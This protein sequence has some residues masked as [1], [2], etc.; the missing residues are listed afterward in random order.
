MRNLCVNAI[1]KRFRSTNALFEENLNFQNELKNAKKYEEIPRLG[2]LKT[3]L[4]YLP[5][6]NSKV[7]LTSKIIQK[8]NYRKISQQRIK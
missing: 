2:P 8:N 5:G 7:K 6:G 1:F 3:S 4:R